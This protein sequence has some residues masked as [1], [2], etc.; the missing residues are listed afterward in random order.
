LPFEFLIEIAFSGTEPSHFIHLLL[1]VDG[2]GSGS[3]GSSD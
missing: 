1:T 3:T 2:S